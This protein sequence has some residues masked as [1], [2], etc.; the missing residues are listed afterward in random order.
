MAAEMSKPATPGNHVRLTAK[1]SAVRVNAIHAMQVCI[2]E[3]FARLT[4]GHHP[5]FIH[6]L[7]S[8][9][10]IIT[11]VSDGLKADHPVR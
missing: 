6:R 11:R 1:R 4:A 10:T 7:G 3:N 9:D 5:A 8:S 2:A